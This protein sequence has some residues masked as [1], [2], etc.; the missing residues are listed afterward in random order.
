MGNA[1]EVNI[2]ESEKEFAR[3]WLMERALR[4]HIK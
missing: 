3:C 4:K 2:R 1:S